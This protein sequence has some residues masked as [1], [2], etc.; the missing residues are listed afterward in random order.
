[1]SA[2]F[3]AVL[4]VF[5]GVV[6]IPERL[7]DVLAFRVKYVNISLLAADLSTNQGAVLGLFSSRLAGNVSSAN[8][9]IATSTDTNLATAVPAPCIGWIVRNGTTDNWMGAT[10]LSSYES[11]QLQRFARPVDLDQFDWA[12]QP[13]NSSLPSPLAHAYSI[14]M[15][16]EFYSTC[17]CQS[18]LVLPY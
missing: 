14:E 11:N 18:R 9:R 17:Q 8:F 15:V 1:M 10:S 2:K 4:N 6:Q 12:V 5:S 13:L 16:I 7:R 3:N